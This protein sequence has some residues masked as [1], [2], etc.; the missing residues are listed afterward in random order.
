MATRLL[1]RINICD[2]GRR[3]FLIIGK[4]LETFDIVSNITSDHRPLYHRTLD[5]Y[6]DGDSL[7]S[8]KGDIG[9]P[10]LIS[11]DHEGDIIS[12]WFDCYTEDSPSILMSAKRIHAFEVELGEFLLSELH[13]VYR[14]SGKTSREINTQ[15]E[16]DIITLYHNTDIMEYERDHSI[17]VMRL[18][19]LGG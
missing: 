5:W 8:E 13:S 17:I 18:E 15:S 7:I 2:V 3:R 10:Y 19:Y 6:K 1:T 11:E 12:D 16:N 14:N 9:L 4:D